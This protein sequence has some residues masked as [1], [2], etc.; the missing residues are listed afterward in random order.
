MEDIV[1]SGGNE[2][3]S[4]VELIMI[5]DDTGGCGVR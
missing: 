5:R 2:W 3:R 1:A 4:V